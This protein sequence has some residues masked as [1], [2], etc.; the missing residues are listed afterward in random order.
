MVDVIER[1]ADGKTRLKMENLDWYTILPALGI[2]AGLIENP[3]KKGPCPMCEGRTRFRFVNDDGR[4]HWYC[5][6]CGSGDAPLLLQKKF[7][8][9]KLEA[10]IRIKDFVMRGVSGGAPP[11]RVA[12]LP[13]KKCS[14]WDRKQLRAA[15]RSSERMVEDSAA[16]RYLSGRV[17]GLKLE[18]LSPCLKVHR[19]LY[20]KYPEEV[21]KKTGEVLR[22]ARVSYLPALLGIVVD[23][24]GKLVTIHRTYLTSE[25]EKAPFA[26]PDQVKKQMTGLRKLHGDHIPVN[27]PTSDDPRTLRILIVC[28]GIET[29]LALVAMTGNRYPVWAMLN[30]GNLSVVDYPA[31]DFDMV[32]IAGDH[33]FADRHGTR[34]GEFY[35]KRA[36]ERCL[37]NGTRAALRI[38][39]VEGEDWC[40]VW[41]K[42]SGGLVAGCA[43]PA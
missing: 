38:P 37:K 19:R 25:G 8:Y 30:A 28:E 26:D 7:G 6:G 15:A 1:L 35:G 21:D 18:W 12:P 20:H 23:V 11:A 22:P 43:I 29:A 2:D 24:K 5:N 32:I 34:A 14:D 27:V 10:I 16:W 36:L 42:Q 33:D 4:G 39:P 40:D 9:S 31:G 13:E 3:R 17:K 41:K